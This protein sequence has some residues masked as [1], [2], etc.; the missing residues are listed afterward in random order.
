[1]E[2]RHYYH[3]TQWFTMYINTDIR[4]R[5]CLYLRY[6]LF[7]VVTQRS[8]VSVL[9]FRSH[10]QGSSSPRISNSLP[11]EKG[12][13]GQCGWPQSTMLTE[14]SYVLQPTDTYSS[15]PISTHS[16]RAITHIYVLF[17]PLAHTIVLLF[18]TGSNVVNIFKFYDSFYTLGVSDFCILYPCRWPATQLTATNSTYKLICV[19]NIC[20][21]VHHAL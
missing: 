9:T 21:S 20:G 3:R 6:G 14:T 10:L 13:C 17:K 7:W 1:M 19:F 11:E 18:C 4:I 2:I 15:Q 12:R 16:Y 5:M 8:G